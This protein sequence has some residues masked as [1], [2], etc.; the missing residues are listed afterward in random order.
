MASPVPHLG[1]VLVLGGCGF[2]GSHIVRLLLKEPSCTT[3]SVISR[4]PTSNIHSGV[5]YHAADLSD[6]PRIATLL[7]QIQPKVIIHASSPRFNLSPSLLYQSNVLGTRALLR[8]VKQVDNVKAFIYASSDAAM[9]PMTNNQIMTEENV[10]IYRE[11]EDGDPYQTT[12]GI[13]DTMVLAANSD[14]GM[15]TAC[16]RFGGAYGEGDPYFIPDAISQLRQGQQKIQVGK[17]ETLRE[18]VYIENVA[19]S[20]ILAAKALLLGNGVNGGRVAGEAFLVSDG[21]PWLFY[22]FLRMVYR[23]AGDRTEMSEVRV[24]P[25]WVVMFFL[26]VSEWVYWVG[27]LGMS[28]P[29]VDRRTMRYLQRPYWFDISKARDR[30]GYEPMVSVEEGVRRAVKWGLEEEKKKERRKAS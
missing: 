18:W 19:S 30:L 24:M 12:K 20:H 7:A 1:S 9:R 28:K 26:G 16:I 22:D 8:Q 11:G 5:T 2:L 25:F 13:A 17:N 14:S 4:T 27:T 15:R 29:E 3:I 21:T 6:E 10:S 23:E